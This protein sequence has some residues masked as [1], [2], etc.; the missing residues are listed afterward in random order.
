MPGLLMFQAQESQDVERGTAR[1][2]PLWHYV[3]E[4]NAA[5]PAAAAPRLRRGA[6]GFQNARA[7][8]R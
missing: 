7:F 3:G 6:G 2:V 1:E 4:T 5:A 8:E